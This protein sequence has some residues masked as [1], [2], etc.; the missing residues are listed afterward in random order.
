MKSVKILILVLLIPLGMF[1][2]SCSKTAE[3]EHLPE[4]CRTYSGFMETASKDMYELIDGINRHDYLNA[5]SIIEL[6]LEVNDPGREIDLDGIQCFQNLTS[7]SLTGVSFKD[8]SEISALKNIQEIN[9]IDTSVVSIDSFK[10]LSKVKSLVITGTKTLQSVKGVEEMTKLT[11]LEM[12]GNG[13]VNIG[14][15][16]QLV[17]LVSLDLSENEMKEIPEI[18]GLTL[19]TSLNLSNNK[20]AGMGEDLSGL[21]NVTNLDLSNNQICDLTKLDDLKNLIVLDL[22]FNDLGCEGVSPDFSSLVNA[23]NL[24]R[25]YLN[26]NDIPSI[27]GLDSI[28]LPNLQVLHLQHNQIDDISYISGYNSIIDLQLQYNALVDISGLSGMTG[29]S[30][31]DLS[32]NAI[33]GFGG[34][35]ELHELQTIDL[36]YNEITVIPPLFS[37]LPLLRE[38][39]LSFNSLDDTSGLEGH[40]TLEIL[41]LSFNT[42]ER[43]IG[44]KDMISLT[45]LTLLGEVDC[46][47]EG[48]P[49]ITNCYPNAI[50]RRNELIWIEN[51]F[52]NLIELELTNLGAFDFPGLS[53]D[54]LF[55]GD[56]LE[57]YSS[58]IN[59][60]GLRYIDWSGLNIKHIDEFSI[61]IPQLEQIYVDDN[62]LTDIR[63]LQNNPNLS[64]IDISQ[65]PITNLSILNGTGV[66]YFDELQVIIASDI[67][68]ENALNGA[69]VDLPNVSRLALYGTNLISITDSLND[70]P[71]LATFSL[72]STDLSEIHNSFNNLFTGTHTISGAQYSLNL[73]GNKVGIIEDSF[74]DSIFSFIYIDDQSTNITDTFI[75]G[76]FNNTLVKGL[77]S[78]DGYFGFNLSDSNYKVISDS[79]ND[80]EAPVMNL[81]NSGIESITTSL[82]NTTAHGYLNLSNNRLSTMEEFDGLNIVELD[83]NGTVVTGH[84]YL[85]NNQLTTVSFITGIEDLKTLSI[86]GQKDDFDAATLHIIDGINDMPSLSILNYADNGFTEIDGLRNLGIS[87]F[88]MDIDDDNNGAEIVTISATSFTDT[89]L[90]TLDLTGHYLGDV[91]FLGNLPNLA[92]LKLFTDLDNISFFTDAVYVDTLSDLEITS[93]LAITTFGPLSGFTNLET[94]FIDSPITVLNDLDNISATQVNV[95]GLSN[96]TEVNNSFNTMSLNVNATYL[97]S[98]SN[99]TN[100][101][102]SFDMIEVTGVILPGDLVITDS[103]NNLPNVGLDLT[104]VT[105]IQIDGES[106]DNLETIEMGNVIL[107]SLAFLADFENLDIISIQ[108]LGVD[109]TDLTH[110][111]DVEVRIDGIDITV[112]SI[113]STLTNNSMLI[114]ENTLNNLSID[115][116]ND[117]L[118]LNI[119]TNVDIT[120]SSANLDLIGGGANIDINGVSLEILTVSDLD[121]SAI[122]TVNADNLSTIID[123]NLNTSVSVLSAIINSES[124]NM[125]ISINTENLLINNDSGNDFTVETSPGGTSILNN[126]ASSVVIDN[127][128]GTL[129]VNNASVTTLSLNGDTDEITLNTLILDDITM[130]GLTTNN[131]NLISNTASLNA[132]GNSDVVIDVNNNNLA[133]LTGTLATG[134]VNLISGYS[135]VYSITGDFDVLDIQNASFTGLSAL[136]SDINTLHMDNANS[137]TGQLLFTNSNVADITI[138]SIIASFDYVNELESSVYMFYPNLTTVAIDGPLTDI[139]IESSAVSLTGL[140]VIANTVTFNTENMDTIGFIDTSD[141]NLLQLN[142]SVDLASVELGLASVDVT[143]ISTNV[144]SLVVNGDNAAS[145]I[146]TSNTLTSLESD[147]N[148]NDLEINH[149]GIG[150][151]SLN[152]VSNTVELISSLTGVLVDSNS[153]IDTVTIS[154]GN[155]ST[156]SANNADITN[157]V[158]SAAP[159]SFNLSGT[160]VDN[161]DISSSVMSNVVI[162]LDL[163]AVVQLNTSAASATVTTNTI[164]ITVTGNDLTINSAILESATVTGDSAI[165]NVTKSNLTFVFDGS[166]ADTLT[167]NTNNIDGITLVDGAS[168][169]QLDLLNTNVSVFSDPF[170]VV[171]KFYVEGSGTAFSIT[172]DISSGELVMDNLN[173]LAITNN[174]VGGFITLT[175]LSNNLALTG[176][177]DEVVVTGN[178]ITALDISGIVV[179]D[180]DLTANALT[181]LDTVTYVTNALTINTT[182]TGFNLTSDVPSIAFTGGISDNLNFTSNVGTTILTTNVKEIALAAPS[183]VLTI[184]GVN[185]DTV[186]GTL[187]ELDMNE[188]TATSIGFDLDASE[189]R[190]QNSNDALNITLSGARTIPLVNV[191]KSGAVVLETNDVVIND[192]GLYPSTISN[193]TVSSLA[194]TID[195]SDVGLLDLDIK[196][197]ATI[198][199]TGDSQDLELLGNALTALDTTGFIAGTMIVDTLVADFNLTSDIPDITFNGG[200]LDT[201]NFTSGSGNRVL[202]TN[203]KEV[204]LT[205]ST[206][207]LT[208]N[209]VNVDSVSGVVSELDMNDSTVASMG[210]DLVSGELR[211]QD[212][213]TALNITLT[214]TGNVTSVDIYKTGAVI[215][216]T[217]D[218]V[219][220]SLGLYPTL[221]SS[222]TVSTLAASIDNSNVDTLDIDVKSLANVL[223]TGTVENVGVVGASLT[224]IDVLGLTVNSGFVMNDTLV[225]TLDFLGGALINSVS[226]VEVNTLATNDITSVT[227][228]LQDTGIT[229]TSDITEQMVIDDFYSVLLSNYTNQEAIDFVRFNALKDVEIDEALAVFRG[230]IYF[231]YILDADLNTSIVDQDYLDFQGY[232]DGYVADLGTTEAQLRLDEGD[233]FVDAIIA[234]IQGVLA[235]PELTLPL[236][237]TI[238]VAVTA[239]IEAQATTDAATSNTNKGWIIG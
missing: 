191:Y 147:I 133:T 47:S 75:S 27:S 86:S 115:M 6:E 178:S 198:T 14:G 63:F 54:T 3:N 89:D 34:L 165:M 161:A 84:L 1:L 207:I 55:F 57:I 206:T 4:Y 195:S 124:A 37:D 126:L 184:N 148:T 221:L 43:L 29:L 96:V 172:A 21:A 190:Y 223:I 162:T 117:L 127:T 12:I 70:L 10:N 91:S 94:L 151:L 183:T 114:I 197:R 194:G 15:L 145:V 5:I 13:I 231:D 46:E 163:L 202:S 76:S 30:G 16:S 192:L 66:D 155:I 11:N 188:S 205:A 131:I 213:N 187:L 141:I 85:Q 236:D 49:L 102:S 181:A 227:T 173:T 171:D 212:S 222:Y 156:F 59:I 225:T 31:I 230:S 100:I 73:Q 99:V 97:V 224:S 119:L 166:L 174:T 177:I 132:V 62:A 61:N 74:N 109:V 153:V 23:A 135:G 65:N 52:V 143:D 18:S 232:L 42:L 22:S 149:S 64:S 110:G 159:A 60:A 80:F 35:T 103:F 201:L 121:S 185:I 113:S 111:N 101:N 9:L 134:T 170:N 214:G 106:F 8:I 92:D 138:N 58:F 129:I 88:F 48:D 116:T 39:N 128:S 78:N 200:V 24:Q 83:A 77:T 67:S 160:N 180:L 136:D 82:V 167:F 157:L 56:E 19:L 118:E 2:S 125:D 90:I 95:A 169:D 123:T 228:L 199:L 53:E 154:S 229:L 120:T 233:P 104:G 164:D 71:S 179:G 146:V 44:L 211:Y 32:H 33:T 112:S 139:E 210:F 196:N 176:A 68:G 36:S 168:V 175:T 72:L 137:L 130:N 25:L 87:E 45:D 81:S 51:S 218:V 208:L 122:L 144:L 189:L 28:N 20:I 219:I 216:E 186:S 93:S 107:T 79:F 98:F 235:N 41:D 50:N 217:N 238:D 40:L 182:G 237:S 69:F 226:T 7:L 209:G 152:V 158:Y 142:D 26:D 203:V 150:I 17:N 38:L 204:V 105:E 215:L 108:G 234:E 220:T 193:Y 140:D 239:E